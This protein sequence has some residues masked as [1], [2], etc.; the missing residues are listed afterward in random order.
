MNCN[1]KTML[2]IGIGMLLIA[3]IAYVAL[4]EFRTWIFA[5]SPTLLFLLC[6]VSML[7]CMKMMNAQNKQSCKKTG[8]GGPGNSDSRLSG[9][10]ASQSLL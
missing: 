9:I 10:F 6:P 4:P 3:G 7:L 2:K 8:R 5:A 1:M